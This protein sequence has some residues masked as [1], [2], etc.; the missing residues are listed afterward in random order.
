MKDLRIRERTVLQIRA[1]GL[2]VLNHANF[3]NPDTRR[4]S[5]TFGQVT[6]L[7]SGNQARIIQLGLQLRF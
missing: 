6:A 7:V 2:N 4:G 5:P 1:E 3:A